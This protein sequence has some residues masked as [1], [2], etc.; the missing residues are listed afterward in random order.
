M[1]TVNSKEFERYFLRTL[2][3]HVRGAKS[4]EDLCGVDGELC[5]ASREACGNRGL[6]EDGELWK[7]TLRESFGSSFVPLSKMLAVILATC[8]SSD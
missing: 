5:P 8:S 2:L 3:L 4:F 7:R 6:L 1:Y